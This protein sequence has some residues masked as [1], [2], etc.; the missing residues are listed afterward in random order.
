M[1]VSINSLIADLPFIF[2]LNK[3]FLDHISFTNINIINLIN[4]LTKYNIFENAH[5]ARTVG[6]YIF[7]VILLA[8][9]KLKFK[10]KNVNNALFI[11]VV[12]FLLISIRPYNDSNIRYTFPILLFYFEFYTS[13]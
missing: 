9:F 7:I 8:T 1:L 10:D 4:I 3:E 12:Y 2:L 6:P 11:S 5:H 13:A